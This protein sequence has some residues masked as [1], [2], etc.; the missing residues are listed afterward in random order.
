[1]VRG[2]EQMISTKEQKVNLEK[3]TA[4]IDL[5]ENAL[6]IVKDGQLTKI[7]AKNH[8]NDEIIWKDGKVLDVYRGERIRM[9]GQEVI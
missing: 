3:M 1:M 8:G 4:E 9:N 2:M 5:T 6:Y 7:T